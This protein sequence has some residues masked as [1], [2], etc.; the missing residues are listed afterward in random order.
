M[1]G[2]IIQILFL[3]IVSYIYPVTDAI[4]FIPS[5]LILLI[6]R[7][8]NTLHYRHWILLSVFIIFKFVG[9][10]GFIYSYIAGEEI[11]KN[12]K[13]IWN[14]IYNLGYISFIGALLW[15]DKLTQRIERNLQNITNKKPE[16][17]NEI[18]YDNEFVKLIYSTDELEYIISENV[19]NANSEILFLSS[20]NNNFV[21]NNQKLFDLI[22]KNIRNKIDFRIM[23]KQK[24]IVAKKYK[25]YD[26]NY[27]LKPIEANLIYIIIDRK[28]II[29]LEKKQK[30]EEIGIYTNQKDKITSYISIFENF[31]LLSVLN[32]K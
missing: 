18:A 4:I 20:I 29:L 3:L 6:L 32:Q 7:K 30:I 13:W 5:F 23:I 25:D 21:I 14:S 16:N 9:D 24:T 1:I 26:I 10:Y 31:W 28:S 8:K 2:L 19:K 27:L 12:T 11:I 15:Y 17:N 22:N